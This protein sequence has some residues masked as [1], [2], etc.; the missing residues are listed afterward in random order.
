MPLYV[1]TKGITYKRIFYG[2]N[3]EKQIQAACDFPDQCGDDFAIRGIAHLIASSTIRMS[4][5]RIDLEGR[6]CSTTFTRSPLSHD[7]R[8]ATKV[9]RGGD[10]E[11]RKA[12][13]KQTAVIGSHSI[14]P[15]KLKRVNLAPL[16][17]L[18]IL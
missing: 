9:S 6:D 12:G 8:P 1:S 7:Q 10:S 5:N 2:F 3:V 16:A 17:L 15:S 13:S 14:C 11:K 4:S 18:S